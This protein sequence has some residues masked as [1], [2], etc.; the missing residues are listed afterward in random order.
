MHAVGPT[1]GAVPC[2]SVVTPVWRNDHAYVKPSVILLSP[3]PTDACG[4]SPAATSRHSAKPRRGA[5]YV[6]R[7][8]VI[9]ASAVYRAS[10]GCALKPAPLACVF[11][12]YFRVN[13][14]HNRGDNGGTLVFGGKMRAKSSFHL[15][16]WREDNALSYNGSI[17][18]R[19]ASR[20]LSL[21]EC[22][23]K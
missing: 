2:V 4:L 20:R 7:R 16:P 11:G 22:F 15:Y 19:G 18:R 3:Q 9:A 5:Q 14:Y 12:A 1:C 8:V 23:A 13:S 21:R 17:S 6:C 10:A